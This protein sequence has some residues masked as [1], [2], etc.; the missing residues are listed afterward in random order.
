MENVDCVV[1]IIMFLIYLYHTD[2]TGYCLMG[3]FG[4]ATS[5]I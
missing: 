4:N 1:S 2:S 3:H 5:V